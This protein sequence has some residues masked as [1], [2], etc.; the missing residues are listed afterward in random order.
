M[1]W[2]W[3][4]GPGWGWVGAITMMLF[5]VGLVAIV[6]W[7][8]SAAAGS[9]EPRR[10]EPERREDPA[11]EILRRRFAGGEI[12]GAEFERRIAALGRFPREG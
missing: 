3:G 5:W 7:A 12:D 2:G 1:M 11:V 4:N 10:R 8:V 6:V 9:R